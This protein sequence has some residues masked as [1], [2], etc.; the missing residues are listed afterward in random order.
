MINLA[1]INQMVDNGT[2]TEEQALTIKN[3]AR[4]NSNAPKEYVIQEYAIVKVG[5]TE[6]EFTFKQAKQT[7][8]EQL[9]ERTEYAKNE[10]KFYKDLVQSLSK[11]R[12]EDV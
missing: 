9:T 7:L 12:K 1:L 11:L 10:W 3:A 2:L 5:E 8:K 4:D 6:G